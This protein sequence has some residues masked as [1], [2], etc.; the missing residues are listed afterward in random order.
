MALTVQRPKRR[1]PRTSA[2]GEGWYGLFDFDLWAYD[3][4]FAADAGDSPLPLSWALRMVDQ[5]IWDITKTCQLRDYEGFLTGTGNFRDQIATVRKYKENRSTSKPT[6]WQAIRDYLV[7][8]HKAT[9]VN[10]IEADDALAIRQTELGDNSIIISRD[11]DLRQVPGWHYGYPIGNQPEFGPWK[12]DDIGEI[13]LITRYK[14][15]PVT[16]EQRV[17]N[18]KIVGGGLKFFYSQVLTGDDTDTYPGL[19]R[20]GASRAYNLLCDTET[21]EEMY[22]VCLAAYQEKYAEDA[23]ERLREQAQLAW[24]VREYDVQNMQP[25]MWREPDVQE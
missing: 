12:Y 7:K 23:A 8:A 18:N 3:I 21:N 1:K 13:E 14:T 9:I 4:G 11:K 25:V 24:M 20:C 5:R 16:G 19:P 22:A 15:D 10:G 6:H 17:S 2:Q